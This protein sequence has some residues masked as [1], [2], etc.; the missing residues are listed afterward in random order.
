MTDELGWVTVLNSKN[1]SGLGRPQLSLFLRFIKDK[2]K[3]FS[4]SKRQCTDKVGN[5]ER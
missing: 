4:L 2:P 1:T 5:S 3:T